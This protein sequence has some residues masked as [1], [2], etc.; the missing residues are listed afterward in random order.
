M[1]S[2]F[3]VISRE[4]GSSMSLFPPD[5]W[6]RLELHAHDSVEEQLRVFALHQG[7][8]VDYGAR[9]QPVHRPPLVNVPR[10][11]Q[12][13]PFPLHV[14]PY[15][16][17]PDVP[18]MGAVA[19]RHERR[20][21]RD[22]DVDVADPSEDVAGLVIAHL[23]RALERRGPRPPEPPDAELAEHLRPA[24]E[25]NRAVRDR[26][27][28]WVPVAVHE[29][30]LRPS[31][32]GA[33]EEARC[34]VLGP[35]LRQVP[36]DD[37]RVVVRGLLLDPGKRPDAAVDVG[38]EEHLHVIRPFFAPAFLLSEAVAAKA[39][40]IS[41]SSALLRFIPRRSFILR[42]VSSTETRW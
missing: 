24:V 16:E 9:S 39:K 23:E 12:A 13:G 2:S 34:E 18:R 15:W 22:Q 40:R 26:H 25:G 37:Y 20:G 3:L 31:G 41:S 27:V 8:R 10:E 28:R 5:T 21:V 35:P 4:K 11:N 42:W 17:G 36:A 30:D 14:L 19:L 29:D 1:V 38:D 7:P 32:S 6:V 33:S